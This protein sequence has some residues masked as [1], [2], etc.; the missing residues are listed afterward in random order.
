MKLRTIAYGQAIT[1]TGRAPV[2]N[3]G[4]WAI[5]LS[6]SCGFSSFKTVAT[7]RFRADGT[8]TFRTGPTLN[9]LLKVL[10]ADRQ[11]V[12]LDVRVQPLLDL[13]LDPV[14]RRPQVYPH[15]LEQVLQTG[16]YKA[17]QASLGRT[18]SL[19]AA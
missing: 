4:P 17:T 2:A 3:P 1:V 6:R 19:R 13:R 11:V 14:R 18:A 8:F 10:V 15:A 5:V 12:N 7:P 16:L 9:T